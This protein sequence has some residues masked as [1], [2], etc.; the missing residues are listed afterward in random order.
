MSIPAR[1]RSER[2]LAVAVALGAWLASG[3]AGAKDRDYAKGRYCS[4]SA[5][6]LLRACRHEVAD[7]FHATRARCINVE[8]ETERGACLDEAAA[9]RAGSSEA[10]REQYQARRS[11]CGELGEARYEPDF[12][13]AHFDDDFERP[14]HPNPY[15]PLGIGFQWEYGG[16][17]EITVRVLDAT[18]DIE[19][20]TC[21]VVNDR[22]EVDGRLVEDTDDWF[23]QRKDG[24]VDYCGESTRDFEFF[25]GD[26][27]EAPELVEIDGS[28][29]TGREGALPGIQL[30]GTPRVGQV[31]RQEWSPGNAEDAA[32]MLSTSYGFGH[33]LELDEG[34]PAAL[35]QR[36]CAANDCVVTGEFTPISPESFER[37]YYA[38]GIGLFL[39]VNPASGEVVRLVDCSFDARCAALPPA[40]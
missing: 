14:T 34:V 16:S 38:A 33:D 11:L 31:Y 23:G 9:Q 30:P 10:C 17:E 1:H 8:D 35:A 19:G 18:K 27:P 28:W 39:A 12:D 25:E 3:P 37:K 6:S 32:R 24:G 29:K 15:F 2:G 5:A 20:V 13:P 21:I 7:D 22:V 4:A 36:L 40:P 26:D